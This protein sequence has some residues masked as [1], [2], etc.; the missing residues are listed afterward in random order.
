MT[1]KFGIDISTWQNPSDI[2][3]DLLAKEI[4]FAIL[5]VGFTGYGTGESLHK[6]DAFERHYEELHKRDVPLGAYWYSC[7]NTVSEG[8]REAKRCLE[9]ISEKTL[10]YP[11]F[12]DVEDSHHQQPSSK[13][14]LT[15]AV[16][17]FCE[18]IE[19]A[20]YYVGI[21]SSSSWF[22][23]EMDYGRL[24]P[25]DLWVAQW[26]AS[27]PS[28]R[29]GIW[30]YTSKGKL[31]GYSGNLDF[32]YAYK[33]YPSIIK[34]AG[35]NKVKNENPKKQRPKV[36]SSKPQNSETNYTVVS[37]DSLWRIAERFLGDGSR[38]PEIKR[39]NGLTSDTIYAGQKL[40]IPGASVTSSIKVGDRVRVTADRY[41]TG[42][43]VPN[44]VKEKVHKVSQVEKTK[45]LL[46]WPD[47]IASWLPI[48]GVK[49]V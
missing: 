25:Y 3:Y 20:G 12:I 8:V 45:V 32:N 4:D 18:T 11:V 47:G 34:G 2:N 43:E 35:L 26:S 30:Q 36:S 27:E 49:K 24:S 21:Y 6:D 39:A 33:D 15:D 19:N 41:A 16:V 40:K 28:M 1:K 29:K 46:G 42:E 9:Y 37:G 48:D 7:A 10:L 5:R 38:Y 14:V 13:K 22:S 17:A 44:W 31:Q 23:Y